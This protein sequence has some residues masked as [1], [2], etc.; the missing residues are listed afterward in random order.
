MRPVPVIH[1]THN[2]QR[3]L[4]GAWIPLDWTW[5]GHWDTANFHQWYHVICKVVWSEVTVC[6][7]YMRTRAQIYWN[8]PSLNTPLSGE[9]DY[10]SERFTYFQY[11]FRL[12]DEDIRYELLRDRSIPLGLNYYLLCSIGFRYKIESPKKCCGLTFLFQVVTNHSK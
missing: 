4:T 5:K 1:F 7:E 8:I 12:E 9:L 6:L 11:L 2:S 3:T 10:S